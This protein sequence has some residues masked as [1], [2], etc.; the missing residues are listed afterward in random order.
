MVSRGLFQG[1]QGCTE[2]ALASLE[3]WAPHRGDQALQGGA[4][5]LRLPALSPRGL[6]TQELVLQPPGEASSHPLQLGPRATFP[7]RGSATALGLGEREE[8]EPLA[9]MGTWRN[10]CMG[11]RSG[12]APFQNQCRHSARSRESNFMTPSLSFLIPNRIN[13]TCYITDLKEGLKM[14][15]NNINRDFPG[16][17]VVKT[18]HFQSRGCGFVP[19]ASCLRSVPASGSGKKLRQR[20]FLVVGG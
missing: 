3:S 6:F 14:A 5:R 18:P 11:L 4:E 9:P 7:L 17:P 19:F 16:S 8:E 15:L 12:Q 20:G 13:N 2:P 10:L 1:L